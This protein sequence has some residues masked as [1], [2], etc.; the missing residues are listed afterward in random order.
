MNVSNIITK[1]NKYDVNIHLN[2]YSEIFKIQIKKNE[3]YIKCFNY[4]Y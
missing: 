1:H 2:E 3:R 4:R